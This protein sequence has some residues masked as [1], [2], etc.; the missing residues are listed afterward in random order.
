MEGRLCGT[1]MERER[2]V[3]AVIL[4]R[5]DTRRAP[6]YARTTQF[7]HRSRPRPPSILELARRRRLCISVMRPRWHPI[8][9][10]RR[11]A[12][13]NMAYTTIYALLP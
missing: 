6:Y 12:E 11:A 7:C 9:R 13:G 2:A 10:L 8:F 4:R 1:E 5:R 3:N